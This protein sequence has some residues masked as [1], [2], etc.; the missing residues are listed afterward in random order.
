MSESE[1]FPDM[2]GK[3]VLEMTCLTDSKTKACLAA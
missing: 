1:G 3:V 2:A